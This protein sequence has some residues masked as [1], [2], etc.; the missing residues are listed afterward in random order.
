M[1]KLFA[2]M[3]ALALVL[4]LCGCALAEGNWYVD[5]GQALAMRMQALA[6]DEAYMGLMMAGSNEETLALKDAF[7]QTDLSKPS[8]AWFMAL[9]E[10][11]E[12]L[13]AIERF[14]ILNS[15]EEAADTLSEL[16]DVGKEELVKRL[17][18]S[19][20]TI[21]AAQ[22]GVKWVTLSSM[23][24]VSASMEEPD[25][26]IPGYL[27]LEFPG[28]YAALVTFSRPLGGYVGASALLAPTGCL[29]TVKPMLTYVK[30]LGLDLELEE[31]EL[32]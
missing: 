7:V 8:A 3:L 16:T 19:A 15:G 12:I 32:E 30:A 22:S 14:S 29:E 17:P 10:K 4:M 21:L 20:A 27:L 31:V 5:G 24:T 18:A 6:A 2:I 13:S 26:F 9:P 23:L 28:D 11:E 1:K 25:G